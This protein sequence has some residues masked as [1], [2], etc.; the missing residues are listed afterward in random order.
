MRKAYA[1][2]GKFRGDENIVSVAFTHN[3]KA[4]FTNDLY[5]NGFIPYVVI[6][7]Q[8]M[9]RLLA[10]G[11]D[12]M[13]LFDVVKKMTTN[14]SVWNDVVEYIEQCSDFIVERMARARAED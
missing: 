12:V 9:A 3:T 5:C 13:A 14:Y 2:I 11:N 7:E 6:T 10:C 1:A 8:M 4:D